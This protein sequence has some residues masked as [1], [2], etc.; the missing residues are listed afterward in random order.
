MNYTI[1]LSTIILGV[2]IFFA[3]SCVANSYLDML[4][5]PPKN[6]IPYTPPQ[7]QVA[8]KNDLYYRSNITTPSPVVTDPAPKS[9]AWEYSKAHPYNPL[10]IKEDI[11][12]IIFAVETVAL[13]GLIYLIHKH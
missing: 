2:Q 4:T 8:L 3:P 1:I 5:T 9:A 12:N 13:G 7:Y 6:H 11:Q 10:S